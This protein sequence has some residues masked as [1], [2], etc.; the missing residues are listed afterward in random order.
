MSAAKQFGVIW[1][2]FQSL[3]DCYYK[4]WFLHIQL[5][6]DLVFSSSKNLRRLSYLANCQQTIVLQIYIIF[7]FLRPFHLQICFFLYR[8]I[9]IAI[10]HIS[11]TNLFTLMSP[12][13]LS[14]T[15]PPIF[16]DMIARR[17]DVVLTQEFDFSVSRPAEV[18]RCSDCRS[19]LQCQISPLSAPCGLRGRK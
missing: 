8:W 16:P 17:T 15:E 19:A 1:S 12:D 10:L 6:S 14:P 18:T 5:Y 4:V 11:L 13:S 3:Q 9:A 7:I 2:S